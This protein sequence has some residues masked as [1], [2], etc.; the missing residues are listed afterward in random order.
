MCNCVHIKKIIANVAV[1]MMF[2][3][4]Y[5]YT[6]TAGAQN[7]MST[8]NNVEM[9][10][11]TQEQ[12]E[13]SANARR[14]VLCLD[15][16]W[17]GT[18]D[19][20]Y[21]DDGSQVLKPSNVLKLCRSV[22]AR[23]AAN[24]GQ[25]AYYDIGVGSL[26]KFPGSS[27]A[28][29]SFFDKYLGGTWGAGFEGNVE[30]ALNYLALNYAEGDQVFIFGFSR[31]A[32]AARGV[33]QFI[34]WA[35][36]LPTK[37]DVYYLPKLFREYVVSKGD[38]DIYEVVNEIN[39]IGVSR[40]PLD[41]FNQINIEYLGVWDT[42]MALGG[43]FRATGDD[44]SVKNRSFYVNSK[45]SRFVTH[46]RQALAID[47]RRWD[48]RPEIWGDYSAAQTLEQRWFAGV[49]SNVG[50]GYIDDGMANIAFHWL[51]DGAKSKGLEVDQDFA[52]KY[53]PFPFD[54]LY[55][56][57]SLKYRILDSV[58]FRLNSGKRNLIDQPETANLSLDKSVIHR[59][60]QDPLERNKDGE[61]KYPDMMG[62]TYRPYNVL[63]YLACMDDLNGFL[64]EMGLDISEDDLP[65][66]VIGEL[67][68]LRPQCTDR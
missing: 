57:Y 13:L 38:R 66:D 68:E 16:T 24:H 37:R 14:L 3:L 30:D 59:I 56:S 31:G 50:G 34:D 58:R 9:M 47:E 64:K 2:L 63:L 18:Y 60:M 17:N 32:A 8:Y 28:F 29:L 65:P 33:T 39:T 61:P 27:N 15:G 12:S 21:R 7:E 46:A 54:K 22:F 49:H 26:A 62:K 36:G 25:I 10:D 53:P 6:A 55:K 45:P 48:F 40:R 44:T 23:D 41:Q 51:L 35:G 43:R 67:D 42:V 20:K 19:K 5:S 11:R 4:L 1:T 52:N